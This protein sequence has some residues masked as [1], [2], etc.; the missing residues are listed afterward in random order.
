M[1]RQL[2]DKTTIVDLINGAM[3]YKKRRYLVS[4]RGYTSYLCVINNKGL[5]YAK[6]FCG[7]I[8]IF[9]MCGMVRLDDAE[10][11][12]R[13]LR[14]SYAVDFGA[15]GNLFPVRLPA[16]FTQSRLQEAGHNGYRYAG[17]LTFRVPHYLF[18]HKVG[19]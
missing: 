18:L 1:I 16:F 17:Y 6:L 2:I 5:E 11:Q 3:L 8:T 12:K 4:W 15:S 14:S 13:L 7:T 19:L 9:S 10:N